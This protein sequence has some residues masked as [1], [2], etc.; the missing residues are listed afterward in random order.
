MAVC[1]FVKT[2]GDQFWVSVSQLISD[3]LYMYN[4]NTRTDENS[5]GV[6]AIGH[7][8]T[9]PTVWNEEPQV[10]QLKD[11]LQGRSICDIQH[12]PTLNPCPTTVSRW[13]FIAQNKTATSY[14][15]SGWAGVQNTALFMIYLDEGCGLILLPPWWS[16]EGRRWID[17]VIP[18]VALPDLLLHRNTRWEHPM[19]NAV[20][21]RSPWHCFCSRGVSWCHG[22]RFSALLYSCFQGT[23]LECTY[24]ITFTVAAW[25]RTS[26]RYDIIITI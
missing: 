5:L 18:I 2:I 10:G 14:T 4:S 23:R 25:V 16:I 20:R 24:I 17:A 15:S 19:G 21:M 7:L 13:C 3:N 26:V 11:F 8:P 6:Y 9:L 1:T 12:Y 22:W